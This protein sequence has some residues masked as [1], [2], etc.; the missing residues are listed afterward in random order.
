[1]FGRKIID[2]NKPH[3]D[4]PVISYRNTYSWNRYSKVHHLLTNLTLKSERK[5]HFRFNWT[6]SQHIF[7]QFIY[8]S[9]YMKFGPIHGQWIYPRHLENPDRRIS[10]STARDACEGRFTNRYIFFKKST[11]NPKGMWHSYFIDKPLNF[12][13]I[14]S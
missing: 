13:K 6:R 5:K 9:I 8:L 3:G 4:R 2:K 7:I 10:R 1:V 14:N 11:H 12:I